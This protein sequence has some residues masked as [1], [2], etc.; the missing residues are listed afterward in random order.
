MIEEG[1]EL[2]ETPE[3]PG[4]LCVPAKWNDGKI[5]LSPYLTVSQRVTTPLLN[6]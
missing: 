1:E 5:R 2:D 3:Q 4:G 6:E